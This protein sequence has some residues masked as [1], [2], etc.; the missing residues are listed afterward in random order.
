MSIR[1]KILIYFSTTVIALTAG[2]LFFI[3]TL[4]AEYREEQFQ[5]RQKEKISSTL[6]LLSEIKG[7]DETLFVALDKSTIHD[8]YNEKL[9]IFDHEKNLIYKS[10]DDLSIDKMRAILNKLSTDQHWIE[11]KE[12]LYDV[13]GLAISNRG[14]LF[15]GIS[16]AYDEFGYAKLNYLRSILIITFSTI[17]LIVVLVSF[18]LSQRISGPLTEIARRINQYDLDKD[19][20]PLQTNESSKEIM[21]LAHRFNELMQKIKEAFAFQKHA[22]HHIS[23]ELKTPISVLVSNFE[24][25]EQETDPRVLK[26]MLAHQ[27]EDTKSLSEII[28]ALL[29][30]S[31]AESGNRLHRAPVRVDELIFD[32]SAELSQLFPAHHFSVDYAEISEDEHKFTVL[33]NERL[34]KSALTNLMHNCQQYSTDHQA[35]INIIPSGDQLK[36]EFINRGKTIREQERQYLFQHFF[37]GANSQGKR[38]FGLGLVFIYKIISLHGGTVTYTT[39]GTDTNLFTVALPL[40]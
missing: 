17:S 29:E 27:K 25:I 24:K 3:Y 5:Q 30:I 38:G 19:N 34:L 35:K 14:K 2:A 37:R 6:Q 36:V 4:F 33:A 11:T 1:T 20:V 28:H 10:V 39:P 21:V 12:E 22:I 32:L 7:L 9:I 31:K 8:F 26:Q 40:S 16:K 23:H 15:Y 13:V 18:Y